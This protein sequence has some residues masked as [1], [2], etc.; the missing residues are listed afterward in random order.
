[1]YC[2]CCDKLPLML[3]IFKDTIFT[4]QKHIDF[5]YYIAYVNTDLDNFHTDILKIKFM[6]FD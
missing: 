5:A 2:S 4:N 6:K 1:M 3:G